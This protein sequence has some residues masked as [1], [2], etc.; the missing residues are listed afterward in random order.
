[1]RRFLACRVNVLFFIGSASFILM[2]CS[3]VLIR[4]REL[5]AHREWDTAHSLWVEYLNSNPQHAEAL[6]GKRKAEE[7]IVSD[8]LVGIKN[9]REAKDLTEALARMEALLELQSRWGYKLDFY[10]AAY[11]A[12]ELRT[13]WSEIESRAKFNISRKQPFKALLV[14]SNYPNIFSSTPEKIRLEVKKDLFASLDS[15]CSQLRSELA[16]AGPRSNELFIKLCKGAFVQNRALASVSENVDR[17]NS[18][19][20]VININGVPKEVYPVF[21]ESVEAAFKGSQWYSEKSNKALTL[22]VEGHM[23]LKVTEKRVVKN[24]EYSVNI[25][26]TQYVPQMRFVQE[27]YD[28][29]E[30]RCVWAYSQNICGNVPVVKYRSVPRWENVPVTR[31][32]TEP[33][34]Y[35]FFADE[36]RNSGVAVIK[37]SYIGVTGKN[38]VTITE[39]LNELKHVHNES[40]PEIGLQPEQ[41]RGSSASDWVKQVATLV[42]SKVE[43][44]MAETWRRYVCGAI[45]GHNK[46]KHLPENILRCEQFADTDREKQLIEDWYK[47]TFG[48]KQD[49]LER[50]ASFDLN[51]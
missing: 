9:A 5:A 28:T 21:S 2:S 27:P 43:G 23:S 8:R 40:M 44:S 3:S 37:T 12:K 11:Q 7:E 16:L 18:I 10:S 36:V 47:K 25:P 34:V 42:S 46:S 38:L 49:E 14:F 17:F 50:V 4:A 6:E 29:T 39:Q 30:Y 13:L 48:L 45:K 51:S 32:R 15:R 35:T 31:Y 20:S 33:R 19:R 22:K 41:D 1:M 24:H 26:Y